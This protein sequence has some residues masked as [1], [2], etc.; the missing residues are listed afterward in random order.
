[1]LRF[2]ARKNA[3]SV[4]VV[5]EQTI[6]N[7][8]RASNPMPATPARRSCKQKVGK[9]HGDQFTR[10]SPDAAQRYQQPVSI[11]LDGRR[12]TFLDPYPF[13]EPINKIASSNVADEEKEAPRRY[14]KATI[15]QAHLR[16][17]A[18]AKVIRLRTCSEALTVSAAIVVPERSQL[19]A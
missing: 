19:W 9:R 17:R 13:A 10:Y 11:L 3:G 18:I 15:P 12:T 6:D 1:M 14:I 4:K 8:E 2:V 5:M 7:D 16:D